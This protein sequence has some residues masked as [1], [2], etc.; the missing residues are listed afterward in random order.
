MYDL[1]LTVDKQVQFMVKGKANVAKLLFQLLHATNICY[2]VTYAAVPFI[3]D[4]N[5]CT[6]LLRS[7]YQCNN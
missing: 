5:V 3:S 1:L 7:Q 6:M 2:S 4:C